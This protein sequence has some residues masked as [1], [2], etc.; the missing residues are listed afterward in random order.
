MSDDLVSALKREFD[1]KCDFIREHGS[2]MTSDQKRAT[3]AYLDDLNDRI[4]AAQRTA[5]IES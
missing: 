5:A 4:L 2:E 1:A 3:R